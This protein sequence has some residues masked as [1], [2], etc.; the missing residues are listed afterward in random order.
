VSSET[1]GKR[2]ASRE[3]T[4]IANTNGNLFILTNIDKFL[5]RFILFFALLFTMI[6]I[7]LCVLSIMYKLFIFLESESITGAEIAD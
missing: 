6:I 5:F 2:F 4:C 7:V 1:C 3:E